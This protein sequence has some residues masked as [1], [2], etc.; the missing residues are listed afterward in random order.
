MPPKRSRNDGSGGGG[1]A[2]CDD[3]YDA[4]KAK[5]LKDTS[6]E[7][8]Q[9]RQKAREEIAR[10]LVD[11][12]EAAAKVMTDVEATAGAITRELQ[13]SRA[14]HEAEKA[15]M[16]KA[17]TFQTNKIRLDVGGRKFTTSLQTLTSVPDTYLASLFS[18]RFELTHDAE[19]EY[20]I[21]RDGKHFD[22]VL[23]FL[24]D[25]KSFKLS[26]DL[27]EGQKEALVVEVKFYGLLDHMMPGP[28][29]AQE[30]VGQS[31]L[32]QTIISG[33]KAE[34]QTAVDQA[35]ALVFD[36]G[37]TT[38]FLKD[39]FQD[40]RFVITDRV[41][42]GSPVWAAVGGEWF[43]Y[44]TIN[45]FMSIGDESTAAAGTAIGHIS[46]A[47][48]LNGG[49]VTAPTK[50]STTWVC[51]A[52]ATLDLQYASAKHLTSSPAWVYIPGMHITVVHGLDDANPTMAAALQQLAALA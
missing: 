40:L 32:Q 6:E 46:N 31:L 8:E 25:S 23:N 1:E 49:T 11:A 17:H 12:H 41:V 2:L 14:K 19:G 44:R 37:S 39:E 18:G 7:L 47:T 48:C 51:N 15:A 5:V 38:P 21:D 36:I 29:L 22:H 24:R 52:Y 3:L 4:V 13:I 28:Y 43:M 42:N 34:R 50:L 27:T 35:R 33:T 45:E 9:E 10:L 26:S 16:H 20:F 30:N